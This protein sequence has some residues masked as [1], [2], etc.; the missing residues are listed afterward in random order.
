VATPRLD[1]VTG[2][3]RFFGLFEGEL[4]AAT[5][6]RAA[7]LTPTTGRS[8]RFVLASGISPGV[9]NCGPYR[10]RADS[11]RIPNR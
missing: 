8:S 4:S 11:G 3:G 9:T 1:A 5:S 6:A 10:C 7:S 2:R